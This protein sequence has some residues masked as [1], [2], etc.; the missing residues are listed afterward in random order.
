[1][2]SPC[3]R[4]GG[5]AYTTRLRQPAAA[6]I[7]SI[8]IRSILRSILDAHQAWRPCPDPDTAEGLCALPNTRRVAN[9]TAVRLGRQVIT[10]HQ[11]RGDILM[12]R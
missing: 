11:L 12:E 1:M 3:H 5:W 4:G 8:L 6:S 10:S 7:R 9:N 2:P